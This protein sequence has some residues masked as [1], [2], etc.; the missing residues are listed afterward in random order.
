MLAMI[1]KLKDFFINCKDVK[2]AV[3]YGSAA[4][5]HLTDY[6]DVDIAIASDREFEIEQLEEISEALEEICGRTI[7]LVDINAAGKRW[8]RKYSARVW[9]C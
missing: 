6:S 1:E 5:N 9:C 7:D 3:I 2:F 4:A 8:C